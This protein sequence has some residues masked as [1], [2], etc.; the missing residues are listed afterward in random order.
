MTQYNTGIV[1]ACHGCGQR[2]PLL[3]GTAD[4]EQ[5]WPRVFDAMEAM[6]ET[7]CPQCHG[8]RWSATMR[9]VEPKA[10]GKAEA[11]P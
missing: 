11:S 4:Q 1:C 6:D 3:I 2:W 5:F 7:A 10:A 9:F 8:N